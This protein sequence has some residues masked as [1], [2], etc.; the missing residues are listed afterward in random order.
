MR[1]LG[2][3]VCLLAILA[4]GINSSKPHARNAQ[5]SRTRLKQ[6]LWILGVFM[7]PLCGDRHV[8]SYL[9]HVSDEQAEMSTLPF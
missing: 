6:S 7:K 1:E 4:S 2:L 3:L 5:T 8:P 9:G